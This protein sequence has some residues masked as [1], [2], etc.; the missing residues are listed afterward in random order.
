M[1]TDTR[2]PQTTDLTG[3]AATTGVTLRGYGAPESGITSGAAATGTEHTTGGTPS[4]DTAGTSAAGFDRRR[5][6]LT[7]ARDVALPTLAYYGLH[8]LGVGDVLALAAGTALAGVTLVVDMVRT[9]RVDVFAGIILAVFAFGLV[10]TFISGDARMMIVKDSLGTGLVGLAFLISTLTAK[11][12]SYLAAVRTLSS[13][14]PA[15]AAAFQARFDSTPAMRR[16]FRRVTAMWG[17]GMTGEAV[18]R[19]VLAYQLPVSTMVW[20]SQVLMVVCF[21]TLGTITGLFVRR[22]RRAR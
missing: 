22:M 21:G 4:A 13:T 17:A 3:P 8:A 15:Q 12:L 18:L 11:P 6:L 14:A 16:T 7:T 5:M 19:I 10:T 20:L 1:S 9:R 2:T